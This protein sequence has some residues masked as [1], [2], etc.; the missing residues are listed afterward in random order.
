MVDP[1]ADL[2]TLKREMATWVDDLPTRE[3]IARS[4]TILG[5]I[6]SQLSAPRCPE[7]GG[8]MTFN[9]ELQADVC[10]HA[11]ESD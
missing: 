11:D 6:I 8:P 5:Y 4:V 9:Q 1:I 2:E 7:C 3:D 10:S